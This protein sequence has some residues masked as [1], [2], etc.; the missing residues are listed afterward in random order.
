M[1]FGDYQNSITVAAMDSRSGRRDGAKYVRSPAGRLGKASGNPTATM[2]S[3][4]IIAKR[5]CRSVGRQSGKDESTVC[6][7]ERVIEATGEVNSLEQALNANLSHSQE[8][9]QFEDAVISLS[10]RFN[11]CPRECP[12]PPNPGLERGFRSTQESCMS[13]RRKRRRQDL[14]FHVPVSG[15]ADMYHGP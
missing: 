10:A 12:A 4:A 9:R 8:T 2:G 13:N 7:V 11:Y 15:R 1:E 3:L 5:K 14:A 6:I